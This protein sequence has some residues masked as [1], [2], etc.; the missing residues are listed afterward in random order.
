VIDAKHA[1]LAGDTNVIDP[2]GRHRPSADRACA[3]GDRDF[4]TLEFATIEGCDAAFQ[5]VDV[6]QRRVRAEPFEREV[7][8]GGEV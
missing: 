8:E 1:Q 5:L 3:R 6:A 2:V 7:D 4:G